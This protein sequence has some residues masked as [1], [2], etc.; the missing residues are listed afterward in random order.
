ME[1]KKVMTT[2]NSLALL[3]RFAI[4]LMIGDIVQQIYTIADSI[5]VGRLIGINAFASVNAAGSLYWLILV[6]L[7]GFSH[8]FGI[9]IAQS[10][11]AKDYAGLKC[12][13]ISSLYL[14]LAFG[15][16]LTAASLISVKPVLLLMRTPSD[17][18]AGT[19]TY[20]TILFSGILF[21]FLNNVLFSIFRA[22]GNSKMPLYVFMAC[23]VLNVIFDIVLVIY[24]SL[25]IAAVAL[26][27]VSVQILSTIFCLWYLIKNTGLQFDRQD[28]RINMT[29]IKNL[30]RLGI[31]IGLRDCISAAGGII[32][33]YFI[34]GYGT[35]YIAGI[36]AAKKLYSVLF[37]IGG[38]I[39][40]AIAVFTAQNYGAGKFDR[41]KQGI[42]AARY[43]MAAG[44]AVIIPVTMFYGRKILRLF[45][46]DNNAQINAVL[47]IAV[48]QM[49]VCLILLPFLYVLFLYRSALQGLGNSFMPMLS[50]IMEAGLRIL[51]VV[52]LPVFF[53][54]WG[55]YI[56]E[57]IGWPIMAIQL[58]ISFAVVYKNKKR[59]RAQ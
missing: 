47:D 36:A 48:E 53:G 13:C 19:I 35:I 14:A 22:L 9:L 52:I 55:I 45:M 42:A 2:G 46:E 8:G 34:N 16:I 17:I 43:I 15:I 7:F 58:C 3:V 26:A 44:L 40:G 51:G 56:A 10:F 25:Q 32:I 41:I 12:I 20:T 1:T 27:T 18:L 39:D 49:T 21:T 33:Q 37:V 6:I 4:P 24:T 5:V 28:F 29:I 30:L 31:P 54:K 59:R 50:G 23:S 38:G 11:G 57:P